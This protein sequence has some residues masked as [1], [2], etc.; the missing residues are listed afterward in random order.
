M[1]PWSLQ[2]VVLGVD[3]ATSSGYCVHVG[4]RP[5][6]WGLARDAFD[7]AHVITIAQAYARDY[8]Q[9]GFVFAFEA[10]EPLRRA[11]S[12]RASLLTL[13]GMLH[14]WL[15][16]LDL[17]RHPSHCRIGIAPS[18]WQRRVLGCTG[19]TPRAERKAQAIAWASAYVHAAIEQDDIADAI[20]IS[21]FAARE[22]VRSH[23]RKKGSW[24]VRKVRK[25][26][27]AVV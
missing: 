3:Q 15:E 10:H 7:R 17:M 26:H 9:P 14:R 18:T 12:S 25:A 24:S 11:K 21:S 6:R 27:R 8:A 19:K 23:A 2:R 13:G 5:V 20:A 1:I 4:I 22:P 16:Q